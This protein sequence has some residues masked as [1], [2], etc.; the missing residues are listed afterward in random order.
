MQ[1]YFN[2][3]DIKSCF[4]KLT[5]CKS[6]EHVLFDS[7]TADTSGVECSSFPLGIEH[8]FYLREVFH[9]SY[10]LLAY[11]LPIVEASHHFV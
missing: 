10:K 1:R 4:V 7:Y 2:A 11:L 9:I 5:V 8:V 3:E 6:S